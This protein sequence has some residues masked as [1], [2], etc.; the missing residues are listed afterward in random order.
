MRVRT[1][2]YE[3]FE[4]DGGEY[5]LVFFVPANM[6]ECSSPEFEERQRF[7]P[8]ERADEFLLIGAVSDQTGG[9]L[10]GFRRSVFFSG[11]FRWQT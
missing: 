11:S 4:R 1:G 6:G 7:G 2:L 8:I 10:K 3:I 5:E 9:G